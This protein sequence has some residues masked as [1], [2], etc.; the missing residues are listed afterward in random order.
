MTDVGLSPAHPIDSH[1]EGPCNGLSVPAP[2]AQ[3]GGGTAGR[4]PIAI[5][6]TLPSAG[7]IDL[8][9]LSYRITSIPEH[10]VVHYVR[11]LPVESALYP[12]N[13]YHGLSD[14]NDASPI[15]PTGRITWSM[16][17]HDCERPKQRGCGFIR[18]KGSRGDEGILFT[19]CSG[20][21]EHYARGRRSHCWSLHCPRCMNDSALRMGS[22]VEEQL[23]SYRI[24]TE[25][26]GG[27]PGPLG[28]WV[29]SPEQEHSKR[30]MQC[31]DTFNGLRKHIESDL[32]EVGARAGALVFHPW[33]Q[34]SDVWALS[35]HFHSI[36]FGFLDTDRF[37]EM[38]PGWIIKKV[39][40]DEA[41]ESIGQTAAYLM[42]HMGLGLVERDAEDVDYDLRFLNHML[43]GLS[44]DQS[45]KGR[46]FSY[47]DDDLSDRALGKGRMVGDVS[48]IDWLSFAKDPLC[49]QTRMTYFGLASNRNIRTVTVERENRTR[50]CREC[51]RPLEVYNGL[52]SLHGEQSTFVFDNTI[53]AFNKDYDIV[54]R[55]IPEIE[56]VSDSKLSL[57]E[58]SPSVSMIV[59]K[60]ETRSIEDRITQVRN[61]S[62]RMPSSSR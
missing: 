37:R 12:A 51:G 35:P 18:E 50:V 30:A 11:E 53:R 27:D 23:N 39:H 61:I 56:A 7:I 41:V 52:C 36:L 20:D 59:S 26:Q 38:N 34:R 25:K 31:I 8:D 19:A 29:V 46:M 28:H 16:P 24:L 60:D 22:R 45:P 15:P 62:R 17:G 1:V 58:L 49:Y 57:A 6:G 9:E 43:P 5:P 32:Q 21:R 33:R 42:T 54:K 40:A 14:G 13:M 47:T 48:G 3:P 2:S 55:V 10:P 4:C 44:E